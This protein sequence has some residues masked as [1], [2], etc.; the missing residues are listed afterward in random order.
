SA[1]NQSTVDTNYRKLQLETM[2]QNASKKNTQKYSTAT[3]NNANQSAYNNQPD[4][5]ATVDNSTAIN[6]DNS[7]NKT[8]TSNVSIT[9]LDG[10]VATNDISAN[11]KKDDKLK[12]NS[13]MDNGISSA[14]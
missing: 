1:N 9:K 3:N 6:I 12:A 7:S 13:M 8:E 14:K 11:T 10:K 2:A 4:N 5:K